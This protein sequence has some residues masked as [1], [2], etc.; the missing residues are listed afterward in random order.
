MAIR[1]VL[2][3]LTLALA[4]AACGSNTPAGDDGCVDPVADC[5]V[6]PPCQVATCTADATCAMVADATQNGTSC[7][8]DLVCDNGACAP[9]SATCGDGI[10]D[11]GE[12]CDFG[13]GNGAGTGCETSC[14][15]SCAMISGS[16][17][18]GD[19]CNGVESC[20][21]VTVSGQGGQRCVAGTAQSDGTGC[22]S[23]RI[24]RNQA[25]TAASCG[26]GF[27]TAPEECDDADQDPVDGCGNDCR[28]SCVSADATRNCTPT[29]ACAGQG[30]CNDATHTCTPGTRLPDNTSCGTGG[31][32]AIG[33]CTQPTCGNGVLEPGET[34]DDGA[35]NGTA[36]SG[37]RTGCTYVCVDPMI[38]C[39]TPPSCQRWTC[40]SAHTCQ[41]VADTVQNGMTCGTA[42]VCNNG[43]C[44]SAAVCGDGVIDASGGETCEP[45]NTLTCDAACHL[46]V[47][48]DSV[49]AG[50]EQCDDG[51]T[52][53]LDGCD[54]SCKFEQ[55]QRANSLA[56]AFNTS[57]Y[58]PAN[59]L[60]GA[61]VGSTART[62]LTSAFATGVQNG[63][64]TI[65]FHALGLDDLTG[66]TDPDLSLGIIGG[67][68]VTGTTTYDG[69]NDLD[70]WYTTDPAKLDAT[71]TPKTIVTASIAAK[72]LNAGPGSFTI[73][74][75]FAGVTVT[76]DMMATRFRANIGLTSTP[77][78]STGGTP[79]HLATENLAPSLVSFSTMTGGE[80]CG[81]TTA[82]SL[83]DV[84]APA[85]LIGCG[86][87][88]CTQCY[89]S[90]NTLLDV[91]IGGCDIFLV[92]QQVKATQPDQARV[93]GDVY[94]FAANAARVVT[95]CTKNGV[96]ATMQD[97]LTN[98][99][100]TSLYRFTTGRVIAK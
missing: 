84:V 59:A 42:L 72:Q 4:L 34:C 28:F 91:Y 16:C 73:T 81:N 6:A 75:V 18:D 67:A 92:G 54:A 64:I 26:D 22:G 95:S 80:L 88:K 1:N 57:S 27:T 70:W 36:G 40:T 46:I 13:T 53:N 3:A 39:G 48:G 63:S 20:G 62:D 58:C 90:A 87:G 43:A 82:K 55:T 9:S 29:D 66:T 51:G 7:G 98:A 47:C 69:T 65:S 97:C 89:T 8:T 79:G 2:V 78:A 5:G 71:R 11:S 74:V 50:T 10:V 49:R 41:A 12:Q 24:C 45:P 93:S 17:E 35:L 86:F 19:A 83:A 94:R 30:T 77:L 37:C 25:C 32:C 52:T 100:Y 44:G 68:P 76:M 60:G 61:I 38:D 21:A 96:A 99:A 23:G 31:Y 33:V 85:A 15:F 14:R 56:M